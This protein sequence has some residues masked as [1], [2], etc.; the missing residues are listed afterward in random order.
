MQV[1]A[2]NTDDTFFIPSS[3]SRI[4]ARELALQEKSLPRLLQGTNLPQT[5]LLPGDETRL[6][7]WQQLRILK[8]ARQLSANNDFGLRLGNRLQ[9]SAHGPIGYLVMASPDL[10]TAL[11]GLRDFL[12]IR[13]P[14]V[15]LEL[16][17]NG[18]WASCMLKHQLPVRDDDK[19][20]MSECFAMLIQ[21]LVETVLGRSVSEAIFN[22]DYPTPSNSAVYSQYIHSQIR[23]N[24]SRT[25]V[26]LPANLLAEPNAA[27][28]S[29]SYSIAQELCRKLMAQVNSSTLTVS[30]RV[31]R[32]LLSQTMGAM[33][34][35]DIAEAMFVSKRTLG[36]RLA[37]E[38]TSYRGILEKLLAEL[39]AHHLQDE[40]LTVEAIAALL[41]YHDSANFRRAFRRWYGLTPSEFR[42]RSGAGQAIEIIIS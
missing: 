39:A 32:L 15:Q 6:T 21:S 5:I 12:P 14:F 4:I 35:S 24:R 36:R 28:D 37:T 42:K 1:R 10:I 20:M 3:Y 33:N 38:N 17:N 25:S 16:E 13:L 26:S 19:Q 27:G 29:G 23:F 11:H 40:R 7:G 30:D 34:E 2:I 9:P 22:F 41:G 18:R 31:R 8:N